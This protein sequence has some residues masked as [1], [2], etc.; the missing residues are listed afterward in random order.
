[1][2]S[3]LVC[4][5]TL[6][7]AVKTQ[8]DSR[9]RTWC[10]HS[11]GQLWEGSPLSPGQMDTSQSQGLYMYQSNDISM[12]IQL[13]YVPN[14]QQFNHIYHFTRKSWPKVY[15]Y[16]SILKPKRKKTT[17]RKQNK[18]SFETSRKHKVTYVLF[19]SSRHMIA[20]LGKCPVFFTQTMP[21][22]HQLNQVLNICYTNF[23]TFFGFYVSCIDYFSLIWKFILKLS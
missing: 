11:L 2:A 19:F 15:R 20:I 5:T 4:A 14:I 18:Y 22:N 13:I 8:P 9:H 21:N 10:P 16:R 17:T 3:K 6:S 7:T 1:M 12:C 23:I